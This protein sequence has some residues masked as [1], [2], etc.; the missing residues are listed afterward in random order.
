MLRKLFGYCALPLLLLLSNSSGNSAVSPSENSSR[1]E[2]GVLERMIVGSGTVTIDLDLECL[3]GTAD[4]N[5]KSSVDNLRFDVGADSFFTIL[6]LNNMLRT[7]ELGSMALTPQSSTLLP[8]PSGMSFSDLVLQRIDWGA[9]FEMVL[10]DKKTGFVFFN[11]EGHS[12]DYDASSHRLQIIGG[13]L[14]ISE[15]FANRLGHPAQ[16]GSVAGKISVA[17]TVYPIEVTKVVNGEPRSVVLPPNPEVPTF[18][19]GPDVIVGDLPSMVQSGASGAQVGLAVA[20]TSCNN[21]NVELN[22]LQLPNTDHPVI[23]QNLYR[24]SGGTTNDARFEQIGQSWLKHA[25]TALQQNACGFGCT[26][27]GTGT[28]LG[29]GCSDPYDTGLNGS[30]TGVGSRAFVNPFTGAFPSTARDHT[31]HTHVGT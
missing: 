9:P 14:L 6:V 10:R 4:T 5:Q 16:A 27:S 29:V 21:G 20:T 3:N 31:G 17:T 19:N 15:E 18:V 2:D 26:S 1:G 30:Q 11:I 22:W 13:R 25:F 12:Y 7:A 23:P 8:A 28:R 24:M